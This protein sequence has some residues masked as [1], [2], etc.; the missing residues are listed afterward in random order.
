MP[1]I[2]EKN[3]ANDDCQI[4]MSF[5]SIKKEEANIKISSL[6]TLFILQLSIRRP[7]FR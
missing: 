7:K 2:K 3:I 5:E 1:I 4:C 6:Y